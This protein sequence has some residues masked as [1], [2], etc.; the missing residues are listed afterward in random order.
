MSKHVGSVAE[1]DQNW[2]TRKESKYNHWIRGAAKNQIQFAFKN[3]YQ[4]FSEFL[5]KD[6]ITKGACLEVGCGRGSISSYFAD[7]GYICTLLD[8][9]SAVL[10][11]AEQIFA[12]NGHQ[13]IFVHGD[14]N[15]LPAKDGTFDITVSIGLLEHFEDIQ[16]PIAEQVRVLKSGGR[17]FGYIVP[18]RPDNVQKY[19][20]WV[21]GLIKM[22]ARLGGS[23]KK[24]IE[25]E[26]IYRSDFDSSRY[27][28]AIQSLP[29]ED[30]QVLG[31]YP[32]PMISHSPEFPFS[33]L[34]SPLEWGLTKF[35]G[36]AMGIR[37]AVR[38]RHPWICREEFG[39]AFLLTFR[40]A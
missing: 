29:V 21:N 7:D 23:Q 6:G 40:K 3:H 19:F 15:A 14:A 32:M 18:E 17:F 1:F 27:L 28:D 39:Q 20:G 37:R 11:T 8:S 13:A 4:V 30:V 12:S 31:L 22:M 25:K 33:L 5:K 10:E 34:P 26:P 38:G 2:Q 24:S 9:S 35:F 16:N 36:V